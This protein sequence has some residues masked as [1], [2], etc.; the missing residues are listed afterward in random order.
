MV[1]FAYELVTAI[2]ILELPFLGYAHQP[3]VVKEFFVFEFL[4]V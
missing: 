4:L 1:F 3:L 2:L